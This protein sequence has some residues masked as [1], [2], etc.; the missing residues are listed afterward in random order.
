MWAAACPTEFRRAA[1]PGGYA[2]QWAWAPHRV[3]AEASQGQTGPEQPRGHVWPAAGTT[4]LCELR[5]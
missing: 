1:A 2:V 3:Y 5:R 4:A